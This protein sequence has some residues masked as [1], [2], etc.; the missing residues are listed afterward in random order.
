MAGA[1]GESRTSQVPRRRSCSRGRGGRAHDWHA[2]GT[3]RKHRAGR[4]ARTQHDRAQLWHS[5]HQG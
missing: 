1:V 5:L 3:R 4:K 2:D